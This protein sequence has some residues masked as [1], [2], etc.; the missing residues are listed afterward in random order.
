MTIGH[1]VVAALLLFTFIYGHKLWLKDI[2]DLNEFEKWMIVLTIILD[3]GII[4]FLIG[5][6]FQWLFSIQI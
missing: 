6:L 4:F 3:L 5:L 1:I 2:S